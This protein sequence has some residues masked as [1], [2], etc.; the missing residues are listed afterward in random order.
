MD[1]SIISS[2]Q[3]F[4]GICNWRSSVQ[5]IELR[6]ISVEITRIAFVTKELSAWK[7]RNKSKEKNMMSSY[8]VCRLI[9]AAE[10]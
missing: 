2:N 7:N 9:L 4:Y 8:D 1:S 3:Y 6:Q 5:R 10:N